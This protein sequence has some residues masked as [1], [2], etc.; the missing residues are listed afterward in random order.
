MSWLLSDR[1]VKSG[2]HGSF[3][4]IKLV[5]GNG[6]TIN[7]IASCRIEIGLGSVAM[8]ARMGSMT[9]TRRTGELARGRDVGGLASA[10]SLDKGTL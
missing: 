5:Q 3:S 4:S 1:S 8:V 9:M 10:C 2:H 7:I 6:L